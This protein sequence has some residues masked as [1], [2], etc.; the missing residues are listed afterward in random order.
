MNKKEK[1]LLI[2]FTILITL[3]FI[4]T[5]ILD[6]IKN[7]FLDYKLLF[8]L[9]ITYF[10]MAK[11]ILSFAFVI[12]SIVLKIENKNK[13]YYFFAYIFN[14]IADFS[15]II[16]FPDNMLISLSAF[17]LVQIFYFIILLNSSNNKTLNFINIFC[18]VFIIILC[19]TIYILLLNNTELLILLV[20][21]YAV[22]LICNVL[23]SLLN[24]KKLPLLSLGLL[25]FLFCD[26]FAGLNAGTNIGILTFDSGTLLYNLSTLKIDLSW[27]FYSICQYF[28]PI[29]ILNN[30]K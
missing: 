5:T 9:L 12:I 18:R 20:I 25:F 13:I 8:Q 14:I 26:I 23:F 17:I 7:C 29:S 19:E 22:N 16:S 30:K 11:I 6:I 15:L 10:N 27:F 2:V 1:I 21:I 24:F 28:L 4:T 3:L